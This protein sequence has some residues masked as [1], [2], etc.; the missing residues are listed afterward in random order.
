M[1]SKLRLEIF[2]FS[3]VSPKKNTTVISHISPLQFQKKTS[4]MSQLFTFTFMHLADAFIQSD[5][6]C[7]QAIHFFLSVCLNFYQYVSIVAP[8]QQWDFIESKL[9]LE[10][11]TTCFSEISPKKTTSSHMHQLLLLDSNENSWRAN[12]DLQSPTFQMFVLR[13][14]PQ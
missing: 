8:Q 14:R 7:I 1:D 4:T 13:K 9:R 2:Y 3:N 6:Q 5:L 11:K 10:I 12:G